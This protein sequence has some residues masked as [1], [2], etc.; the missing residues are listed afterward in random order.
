MSD[1]TVATPL[2]FKDAL[3][4]LDT[5]SN[6]TF[7]N[8]AW[9]PSLKRNIVLKEI[10]AKQQK[11]LLETAIDSS[12]YKSTFSKT[13]YEIVT[14]NSTEP[15]E[16][17][18]SLNLADKLS[19]ALSLRSQISSSV[20]VDFDTAEEFDIAP[21]LENIS[22]YVAP[23]PKII[24]ITKSGISIS[25]TLFLPTML[26]DF[27][28]DSYLLKNKKKTDDTE[29][30]RSLIT[31]A[32]LN[33]ASKYIRDVSANDEDLRYSTM[34]IAQKIQVVEKLPAALIQQLVDVVT[35][36]KKE[37]EQLVTVT[38]RVNPKETRVV[39]IDSMLFLTN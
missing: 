20:K 21:L 34:S 8:E 18:E 3:G 33:E 1:N 14:A 13:F 28:F 17:I 5:L 22:K 26:N 32:F 10:S 31:D 9:S 36:W 23:E 15:K 19:L 39:E 6:E 38:S 24:S 27:L 35:A 7:V 25:L 2:S 16:V 12:M 37:L 29:E 4:I 30:V 11:A